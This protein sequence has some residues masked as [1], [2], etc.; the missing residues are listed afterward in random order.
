MIHLNIGSNLK[1]KYGSKFDNISIA[2]SL[3]INQ[4]LN[5]KKFLIFMKHHLIQIKVLPKF[6]NIGLSGQYEL[7]IN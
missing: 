6:L 2:I 1:S 4:N 7:I 5:I 3:L